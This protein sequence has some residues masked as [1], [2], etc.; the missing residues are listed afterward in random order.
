MVGERAEG[1]CKDYVLEKRRALVADGV[2]AADL[3]IAIVMT[4][5]GETHAVL[6]VRT[7]RGELV[8]DSL[9]QWIQPWRKVHYKWIKRQAPGQQLTWVS[10]G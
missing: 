4:P 7:D 5:W 8:L 3:S 2:P 1:D 10:L 6:L 9:S